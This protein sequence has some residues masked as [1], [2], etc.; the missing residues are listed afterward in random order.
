MVGFG[1][2]LYP[3]HF[4]QLVPGWPQ[5]GDGLGVLFEKLPAAGGPRVLPKVGRTLQESWFLHPCSLLML[6]YTYI[7]YI[8]YMYIIYIMFFF[9]VNLHIFISIEYIHTL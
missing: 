2:V 7:L 8:L 5:G 9:Y 3:S 1:V 4:V 6:I